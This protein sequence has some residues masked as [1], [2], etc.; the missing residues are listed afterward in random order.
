M[1]RSFNYARWSALRRVAQNADEFDRLE[2]AVRAWE[3]ATREAFLAAYAG[4]MASVEP[5]LPVDADLLGSVR[6]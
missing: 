4:T 5:A 2:P 1:L 3:F 6:T